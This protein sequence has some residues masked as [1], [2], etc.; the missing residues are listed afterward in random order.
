MNDQITPVTVLSM[1]RR[2]LVKEN[3]VAKQFNQ[4][5]GAGN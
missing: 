2:Y 5:V 1:V 3:E 4:W